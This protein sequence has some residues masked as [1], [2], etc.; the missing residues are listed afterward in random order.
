MRVE[1]KICRM[2][3]DYRPMSRL[4]RERLRRCEI[5]CGEIAPG[6]ATVFGDQGWGGVSS[7]NFIMTEIKETRVDET[8]AL[9][10]STFMRA[11]GL[12]CPSKTGMQ[13]R[14]EPLE[15]FGLKVYQVKTERP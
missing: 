2:M 13:Q 14:T 1:K 7:A 10:H 11:V 3:V 4:R 6:Y 12:V 5:I 8:R 9:R 15:P